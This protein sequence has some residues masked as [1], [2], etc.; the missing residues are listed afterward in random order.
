MDI[1]AYLMVEKNENSKR[2][3]K[4]ASHTK[5]IFKKKKV[6]AMSK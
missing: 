4:G 2:Q 6:L 5:K 1:M 3:P